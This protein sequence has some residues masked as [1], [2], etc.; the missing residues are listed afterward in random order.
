MN[1]RSP[2]AA[3]LCA[4]LACAF[5]APAFAQP[6]AP[7]KPVPVP[8]E[9]K[10]Y[11][12]QVWRADADAD[13]EARCKA[14]PDLPGNQWRPGAA[15]AR[16]A[17]L[18]APAWSLQQ[19]QALL[20]QPEGAAELERR[21]AKLHRAHFE[22]L[23]Q[24]EQIFRSLAAFDASEQAGTLAERWLALAP[25]SAYAH[26]ALANHYMDQGTRA[27]GTASVGHTSQ[28]RLM[29]MDEAF[30]KAVPLYQQAL[31]LDPTLS[32]ACSQLAAI[33]RNVSRSLHDSAV[34]QCLQVDP[35]SYYI[36]YG[37]IMAAQPNWG[38]SM[39][40]MREAV[41][42]AAARTERNPVLGAVL[43]EA[44]GFPLSPQAGVEVDAQK[45]A[46]VVRMAPSGTLMSYAASAYSDKGEAWPAF[47]LAS[48]AT[49]F[50]PNN[51][52][53]RN[54]RAWALLSLGYP[55]RAIGDIQ[56][57]LK[58]EPDNGFYLAAMTWALSRTQG[59]AAALP[60]SKAL[61]AAEG[62]RPTGMTHYCEGLLEAGP[63]DPETLACTERLVE[64]FPGFVAALGVRAK[65]L[66][67]AE[68]PG[69]AEAVRKFAVVR[70][71]LAE[72]TEWRYL[73]DESRQWQAKLGTAPKDGGAR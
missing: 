49:R 60:Y 25:E 23:S 53:F 3:A 54:T 55:E 7:S 24:R 62:F 13:E 38:G 1:L 46:E 8:A 42:Y 39:E 50:W 67:L 45:M 5:A 33:G 34:A 22:E 66:Y 18:R 63:R 43:A 52:D 30:G 64:E 61:M 26:V 16:C 72:H 14:Y 36:V 37:R 17:L 41:A 73:I 51:P 68:D 27:R 11:W 65:A 28:R 69:A 35:D 32:V 31:R 20:D 71:Q 29:S 56:V 70:E 19:I 40:L 15:Q 4:A 2:L 21:F 59:K 48:Q 57:A 6:P 9:L 12:K 44:A 10:A 58:A 47:V